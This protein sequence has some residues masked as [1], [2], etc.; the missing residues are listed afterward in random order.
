MSMVIFGNK[1]EESLGKKEMIVADNKY[2]SC[3]SSIKCLSLF[4]LE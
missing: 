3:L 1:N 4:L 2:F